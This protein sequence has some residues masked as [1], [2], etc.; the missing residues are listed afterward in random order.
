MRAD[1]GEGAT[2][3]RRDEVRGE[4]RRGEAPK[5]IN[6]RR[7][8]VYGLRNQLC[9]SSRKLKVD[10][11]CIVRAL[12]PVVPLGLLVLVEPHG[13]PHHHQRAAISCPDGTTG[14]GI[15]GPLGL[16]L[17]GPMQRRE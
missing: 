17:C 13:V 9:L 15:T 11:R 3:V 6:R 8:A 16:Y 2:Q 12:Q 1:S 4:A 5:G 7:H 14:A 10:D